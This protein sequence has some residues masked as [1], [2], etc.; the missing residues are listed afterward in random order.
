M[1][2]GI[3]SILA[4]ALLAACGP[5]G[6]VVKP[7]AVPSV[8]PSA[9]A[10]GR[11]IADGG[12]VFALPDGRTAA[13]PTTV[14]VPLP[15]SILGLHDIGLI[16]DHG[17]EVI[18]NNGGGVIANNGGNAVAHRRLLADAPAL[19]PSLAVFLGDQLHVYVA[20]TSM[21][22]HLLAA[23]ASGH[24]Q[25]GQP[26][27]A[28]DDKGQP[29]TLQATPLGD[30]VRL[31][32]GTGASGTDGQIVGMVFSSALQGQ[33]VVHAPADASGASR[34]M[35]LLFDLGR[36]NG[37]ADLVEDGPKGRTRA[38]LELGH[39]DQPRPG[40]PAYVLQFGARRYAAGTQQLVDVSGSVARFLA[41]GSAAALILQLDL[42]KGGE[43]HP[44][45]GPFAA[46]AA[47]QTTNLTPDHYMDG[48]GKD[49]SHDQAPTGLRALLPM[50]PDV[51]KALAPDLGPGDPN[52]DPLF[53]FPQ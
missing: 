51:G 38:H 19:P 21:V 47:G 31:E 39:N 7:K 41:D 34:T 18:A 14:A 28:T 43:P 13:L 27:H 26:F 3:A 50:A 35:S 45:P 29:I 9:A 48:Q 23:A 52:A 8:L 30:H 36:G 24:L 46:I 40:E 6:G 5:T 11:V 10:G 2:R 44:V 33:V 17:S 16:G 37:I 1:A 49:L 25:P 32:V 4:C 15:P 20:L 42:G 53:A 22:D 12:V